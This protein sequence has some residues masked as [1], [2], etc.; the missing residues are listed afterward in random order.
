MWVGTKSGRSRD[1]FQESRTWTL[2]ARDSSILVSQSCFEGFGLWDRR[3][4]WCCPPASTGRSVTAGK[5]SLL[6]ALGPRSCRVAAGQEPMQQAKESYL[7]MV[8]RAV[9][10][11]NRRLGRSQHTGWLEQRLGTGMSLEAAVDVQW[12][13]SRLWGWEEDLYRIAL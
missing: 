6:V 11:W 3:Q 12:Q 5:K 10:W 2:S 8:S 7:Y 1:A 13:G 9:A 4:R